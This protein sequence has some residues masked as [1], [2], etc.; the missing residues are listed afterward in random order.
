MKNP[1][2]VQNPQN[3]DNDTN[4][5]RHQEICVPARPIGT[6]I[7]DNNERICLGGGISTELTERRSHPPLTAE[8]R[9]AAPLNPPDI[10]LHQQLINRV[11]RAL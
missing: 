2:N 5:I 3:R 4:R 8:G 6:T 9:I 7:R 10:Q 1:A 11:A